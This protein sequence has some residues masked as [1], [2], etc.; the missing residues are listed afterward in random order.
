M[1]VA[2]VPTASLP[3]RG[4]KETTCVVRYTVRVPVTILPTNSQ[5]TPTNQIPYHVIASHHVNKAPPFLY[6]PTTDLPLRL[7]QNYS[8]HLRFLFA[9]FILSDSTIFELASFLPTAPI[10]TFRTP[11]STMP[12]TPVQP[13]TTQP[14]V[15]G[16]GPEAPTATAGPSESSI[17]EPAADD[18]VMTDAPATEHAPVTM[19][20][21]QMFP[22]ATLPSMASTASP[23]AVA[24]PSVASNGPSP[25]PG[26]TGTPIR[27]ANGAQEPSSSRA[28]SAHPDAAFKIPEKAVP[29]G[30]PVRRYL[31]TKVTVVL[32]EGMKQIAKEQPKDPLRKLGEFLLQRSKEL[33]GT[34]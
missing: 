19:I 29:H 33:E 8:A 6:Y 5:P 25:A 26:R 18:A 21:P 28:G 17:P 11:T 22:Q 24:A 9:S 30:D 16:P 13:T 20:F 1:K 4:E 32:L 7:H 12:E 15:D 10:S 34:E 27:N 31:N 14:S 3:T 2:I 23:P